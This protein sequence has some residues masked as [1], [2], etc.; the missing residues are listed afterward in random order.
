MFHALIHHYD[1]RALLIAVEYKGQLFL[2]SKQNHFYPEVPATVRATSVTGPMLTHKE[3]DWE[4]ECYNGAATMERARE[5]C[6]VH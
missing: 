1:K 6:N 5:I 3:V 2:G 4:L